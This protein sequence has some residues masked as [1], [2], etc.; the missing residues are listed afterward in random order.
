[1]IA[2]STEIRDILMKALNEIQEKY[3]MAIDRIDVNWEH[4]KAMGDEKTAYIFRD[5]TI[6]GYV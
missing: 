5:I 4:P 1:M 6:T 3:G 2:I